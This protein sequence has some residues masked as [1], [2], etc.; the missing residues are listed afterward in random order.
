MRG[1]GVLSLFVFYMFVGDVCI[2]KGTCE[3][4]LIGCLYTSEV[5]CLY[6]EFFCDPYTVFVGMSQIFFQ[7][8]KFAISNLKKLHLFY[9]LVLVCC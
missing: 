1:N 5:C 2:Y 3:R 9:V 6:M 7:A 8:Y 4:C